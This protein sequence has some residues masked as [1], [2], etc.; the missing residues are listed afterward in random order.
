MAEF[1]GTSAPAFGS[2]GSGSGGALAS[3]VVLQT[4]VQPAAPTGSQLH[5]L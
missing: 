3:A 5:I 2:S 4:L 1:L